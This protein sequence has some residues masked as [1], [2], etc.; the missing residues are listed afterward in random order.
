MSGDGTRTVVDLIK[1]AVENATGKVGTGHRVG[2]HLLLRSSEL[3]AVCDLLGRLRRLR[4]D[5]GLCQGPAEKDLVFRTYAFTCAYPSCGT[6]VETEVALPSNGLDGTS[7][8]S[9]SGQR[10]D[11]RWARREL[12][13]LAVTT[14]D[15][16]PGCHT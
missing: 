16:V 7:C 6:Q 5:E 14:K 9:R 13:D 10:S 8:C 4:R 12:P 3:E 11:N 1:S 2:A 15:D